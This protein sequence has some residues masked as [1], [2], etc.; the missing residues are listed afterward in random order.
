[1]RTPDELDQLFVSEKLHPADLKPFFV[2]KLEQI[3]QPIR[4]SIDAKELSNL[5]KAASLNAN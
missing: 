2:Q 1:V 5:L 4:A 3:L